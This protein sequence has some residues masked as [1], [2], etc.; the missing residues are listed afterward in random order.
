MVLGDIGFQDRGFTVDSKAMFS[1]DSECCLT[2]E[3]VQKSL[4]ETWSKL[5]FDK[6]SAPPQEINRQDTTLSRCMGM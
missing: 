1:N 4:N 3:A 2:A 5:K 6:T